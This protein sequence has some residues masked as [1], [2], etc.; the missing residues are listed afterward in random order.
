[1]PSRIEI[2]GA[3][4]HN[5]KNIDVDIPR[6]RLVVI[7]GPSGSGKS[8]LAF[9]T[10]FAEGQRRY[11]ESLS[12]HAR[13]FLS[14]LAKPEVE[15]IDGLSPTIAIDQHAAARN[16]RSTVGTATEIY[17]FVR[18][19]YS[20]AGQPHCPSCGKPVSSMT[21]DQMVDRILALPQGTRL[22]VLSPVARQVKGNLK[23]L[24]E[25]LRRDGFVRVMID[26][27]VHDLSEQIALDGRGLHDV[28]VYVDRL[29]NEGRIRNR[30]AD[31]IELALKESGGAVTISLLEGDDLTFTDTCSCIDCGVATTTVDLSPA[32]F[33]FNSPAGAC[34]ACDGLGW[35]LY[36]DEGRIIPD[37]TLHLRDG[38][39]APWA[40]RN[41]PYYQQLLDAVAT[42]YAI[43]P[44]TPWID[45]PETQR[46]LLL[47]GTD[48]EIEFTV[49]KD[50]NRFSF[51]RGF[52]GVIPNLERRRKEYERRRREG[53]QAE[54]Q[55]FLSDEFHRYMG[56]RR[57]ETCKG[58]R[59]RKESLHVTVGDANI[60]ELAAMTVGQCLR[61]FAGLSL[62]PRQQAVAE[63]ILSEIR[64]RLRF[65]DE[66]GL[67]YLTL[68]RATSTLSG[69]EAQRIRLA[70]QIGAALVGVTYVLDEPSIGLHQRDNE[71]LLGT[72][73]SL[74]DQGNTVVVVEHDPDTIRAADHVIDMGP[75]AGVRGGEVVATGTPDE[76]AANPGSIT[77]GYLSGRLRIEHPARRRQ[78]GSRAIVLEGARTNNLAG[79]TVR[80]PLGV[81]V[82]V[83]G[84]SGSGKSSL[85]IDTLLLA[86]KRE[87][88][89]VGGEELAL[90]RITGF[91]HID[92]IIDID[93]SPIG[94][95]PR[96]NPAT[97][98]GVFTFIRD[99]FAELP[100]SKA[101][102]YKP[103]RYSFN[104]KGGRCE[105]CQGDGLLR[106]EM[107]FLPDVF[108]TCEVCGGRR[109]NRETL[110]VRYKGLNIAE[111]LDLTC[112]QAHDLL[113]SHPKIRQKLAVL[114]QVGLGYLRLGQN[115]ATL[116][117]GEAQ[118]IKLSRELSR[119]ATGKTLYVLDEPTTGLHFD[120]VKKL[121]EVLHELVDQ[122]NTVIVIEHNLDVIRSADW[123]IDLGPEGGAGGGQVVAAGTPE[124]VA[125]CAASHTGRYL[126]TALSPAASRRKAR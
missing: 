66:V 113:E 81:L 89:H 36:F 67:D 43:D 42:K 92:K 49:E 74:R 121:M 108:V 44:F 21:V 51:K 31:S 73:R 2:R 86:V 48:E 72:L 29:V 105:A 47:R 94:R 19:L 120:D 110:E 52:E 100:D 18:L 63:R 96:S 6:D 84:V 11:V 69:G 88:Y 101:R 68:D 15:S 59:L 64:S 125:R 12:P 98:T 124:D 80:L 23:P 24:L 54:V 1:M 10:I 55:D 7:T 111:V 75:G 104:V 116:S 118:R 119:K 60:A 38:A 95:T 50:D 106:I 45:L 20:R 97:F 70:T 30:L 8:S 77:G 58:A 37:P 53:Q 78:A 79:I 22:S 40:R 123:V 25:R 82:A 4:T 14:Q 85:I 76:I 114:R 91:R 35:V 61:F 115:A 62:T 65:L 46:Q 83:T 126:Q 33:S 117:G 3:R 9:D 34:Q 87:L 16:P 102:G 71:R 39:I 27:E 122:G 107:N 90:E 28:S 99:L 57:C 93:Q 17:D 26:D 112:N 56:T 103:G 13:Q 41:T 32:A 109:Y 5:L